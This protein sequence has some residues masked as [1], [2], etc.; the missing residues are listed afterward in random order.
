MKD[1]ELDQSWKVCIINFS[2]TCS[3]I[4]LVVKQFF[5]SVWETI[6]Q[7]SPFPLQ[8]MYTELGS[9][10]GFG[11]RSIVSLLGITDWVQKRCHQPRVSQEQSQ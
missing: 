11:V 7:V 6:L 3:C 5:S 8:D 1:V 2:N 10:S 4:A 9:I